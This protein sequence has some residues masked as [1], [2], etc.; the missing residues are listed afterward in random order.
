MTVHFE[1]L[2]A[3][4]PEASRLISELDAELRRRYPGQPVWGIEA[5]GFRAAG[6]YFVVLREQPGTPAVA[7]G[8]FRPVTPEC[9]EIKRMYVEPAARG[10]GHAKAVLRH[11]EAVAQARG[12]RGFVLE[13]G[14]AQPEAMGLYRRLG[15][16][17]IPVY[18]DYVGSSCSVC[19]A[20][21]AGPGSRR[22]ELL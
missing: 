10:R 15:Y 9:V 19:F 11:L 21:G 13:T 17:Q 7:C 22:E 5:V 6:G 1:S 8:A 4:H 14:L 16:F 20:K 12:Y 18:G 2:D 3:G